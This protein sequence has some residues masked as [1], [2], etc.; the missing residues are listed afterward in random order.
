MEKFFM[1]PLRKIHHWP[2]LEKSF[3]RPWSLQNRA[4][5][6]DHCLFNTR[7]ACRLDTV[8]IVTYITAAFSASG[9]AHGNA[10]AAADNKAAQINRTSDLN[11]LPP[12]SSGV[13][14]NRQ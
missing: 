12:Q 2:P 8:T 6:G 5:I 4:T 7:H 1:L 9:K 3:R 11:S 13:A 14:P 10:L